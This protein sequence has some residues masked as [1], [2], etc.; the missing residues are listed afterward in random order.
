MKIL[1]VSPFAPYDT[2]PHGGGQ[3]HN[4]FLKYIKSNTNFSITLISLCGKEE[5]KKLDLD[6]YGIDNIVKVYDKN[7]KNTLMDFFSDKFLIKKDGG[8]LN[9][10]KRCLLLEAIGEFQSKREKPDVIIT[11]WTQATLLYDEIA[12]C[13]PDSKYIA[14]EED[15]AFLSYF[16]KMEK[17]H[18]LYRVY[19]RIK[20]NCLKT[21]EVNTLLN[22][23]IVIT[24]N[25]KDTNLLL[26][27]GINEAA[28]LQMCSYHGNYKNLVYKSSSE[29]I[30]FLGSMS[31]Q[32]NYLS[33]IWFI[34]NVLNQ[35]EES[36]RFVVVGSNPPDK[37]LKY[38]SKRIE[39]TGYVND[40]S[41]YFENSLCFVSPLILGAGIKIKILEALSA[42]LPV[43]TNKIGAEGIDLTNEENY[44]HCEK[45]EE[46][47]EAINRLRHD[48]K[49]RRKL[50]TNGKLHVA[51]FF[52]VD[53]SLDRLIGKI[54]SYDKNN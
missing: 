43:V 51:N 30:L 17:V 16:R 35:L 34:E 38:N 18:G 53:A 7:Q 6:R 32:E 54:E 11:Q 10:K 15:V 40:V 3:N 45:P 20:Y 1:W 37:L 22:Y 41:P 33:V 42:G 31:R 5:W 13:F 26:N 47:V 14:I 50:S 25:K 4:Y 12:M 39:I 19:K 24:L 52:D 2:V 46:Y 44:L 49:L 48:D 27:E 36:Y 21:A 23:D 29:N 8:L 28:I 9:N